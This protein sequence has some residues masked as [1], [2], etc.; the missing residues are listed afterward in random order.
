MYGINEDLKQK[1]LL[2]IPTEFKNILEKCY[3]KL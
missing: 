1:A 3:K 2:K